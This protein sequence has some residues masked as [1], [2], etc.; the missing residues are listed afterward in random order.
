MRDA[1]SSTVTL[2]RSV[3][4]GIGSFDCNRSEVFHPSTIL[5]L[6]GTGKPEWRDNPGVQPPF[7]AAADR[8]QAQPELASPTFASLLSEFWQGRGAGI[9]AGE[10]AF[11]R[12][13]LCDPARSQ[14]ECW[15][16]GK[17]AGPTST[18]E[19]DGTLV[20]SCA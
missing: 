10:P 6:C 11:M 14:Q 12:A 1:S 7:Q 4:R 8:E 17:T 19:W 2:A 16:A 18:V 15:L 13:S 9:L 20:Y 5:L 3:S